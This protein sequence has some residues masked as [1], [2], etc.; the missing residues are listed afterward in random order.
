MIFGVDTIP[1]YQRQG[2]AEKLIR[3]VIEDAKKQGR[4]GVVLTCK[5]KL[6]HYYEKFG[7][8]NEGVSDSIHGGAVWYDMRLNLK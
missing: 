5:E 1:E 6:L 7:F 8:M 4:L 3:E 2:C